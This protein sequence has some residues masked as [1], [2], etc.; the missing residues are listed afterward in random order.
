MLQYDTKQRGLAFPADGLRGTHKNPSRSPLTPNNGGTG[1]RDSD[2]PIIGGGGR[3]IRHLAEVVG[4]GVCYTGRKGNVVG[5][6]PKRMMIVP[7]TE[8]EAALAPFR[9]EMARAILE[10]LL[11]T[12]DDAIFSKS[13]DNVIV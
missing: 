10:T 1:E 6:R 12:S 13:L 8:E 3:I 5:N 2:S 11:E 9:G 4:V 7:L